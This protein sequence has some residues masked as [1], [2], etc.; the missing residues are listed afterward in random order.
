MGEKSRQTF[1]L[2]EEGDGKKEA[3][4]FELRLI[5]GDKLKCRIIFESIGWGV[6]CGKNGWALRTLKEKYRQQYNVEDWKK[7]Y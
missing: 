1:K 3:V 7:T 4:S 2:G 5:E 6:R